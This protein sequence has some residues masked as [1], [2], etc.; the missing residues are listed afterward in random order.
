MSDQTTHAQMLLAARDQ[1]EAISRAVADGGGQRVAFLDEAESGT[2]VD[3]EV[4]ML[5]CVQATVCTLFEM[6]VRH[7]HDSYDAIRILNSGGWGKAL[8]ELEQRG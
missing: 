3:L 7:R 6:L 5:G 4:S 8:L 1:I 2:E